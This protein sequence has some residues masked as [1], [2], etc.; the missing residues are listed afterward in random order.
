[1]NCFFSSITVIPVVVDDDGG[2]DDGSLERI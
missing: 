2:V 1:M